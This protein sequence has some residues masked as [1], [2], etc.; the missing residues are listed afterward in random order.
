M[1]C[2]DEA[3]FGIRALLKGMGEADAVTPRTAIAN[4]VC[5]ALAPLGVEVNEAPL[6][7]AR[8]RA[9]LESASTTAGWNEAGR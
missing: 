4:A 7:P 9:A 5:D 6:T 1:E 2:S 3:G 8:G